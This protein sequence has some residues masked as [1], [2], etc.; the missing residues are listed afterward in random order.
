MGKRSDF[1]TY[2]RREILKQSLFGGLGAA[3]SVGMAGCDS[4]QSVSQKPSEIPQNAH[5]FG[6]LLEPNADGVRLPDGFTCRVIARSGELPYPGGG[7]AWHDAPDGGTTFAIEDGGWVYVSNSEI[8]SGQGGC[9]ALRFDSSGNIIS[10][11]PILSGTSRNCAGGP[12]PW[13]TWLSCEEIA[14]GYV[15]ECDPLGGFIPQRRYALGRF[16]HEAAAVEPATGRVFLTEDQQDG[17]LYRYVPASVSADGVPD[18]INGELQAAE[19]LGENEGPV[20]WHKV[21]D[22]DGISTPTRMQVSRS[23]VFNR[24]EGA[25]YHNGKLYV[26]TTGDNRIWMYDVNLDYISVIYD[27]DFFDNPILTGVDNISV[28]STGDIYIAEDGP[29]EPQLISLS[30]RGELAPVVQLV[31]HSQSEITGP[32]FDPYG[33]RLYFSSQRGTTGNSSSGVT[34]EVIGPFH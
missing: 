19:I 21:P 12:T 7:Y 25:W 32:A 9:S 23:A 24:G 17:C 5:G 11:Y 14:N 20:V 29:A 3:F 4:R 18:L 6:P 33:L 31:G 1:S 10:A 30:S 15:W 13:G 16:Q 26:A 34:F 27:D 22:P 8:S 2:S 28:S